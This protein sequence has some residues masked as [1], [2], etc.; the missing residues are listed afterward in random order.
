MKA[1]A[2]DFERAR[3]RARWLTMML[4][5]LGLGTYLGLAPTLTPKA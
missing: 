4:G 3:Q 5:V 2:T 1:V